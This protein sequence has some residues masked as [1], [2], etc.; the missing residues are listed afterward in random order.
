M[1]IT[2]WI[3]MA[4]AAVKGSVSIGSTSKLAVVD[5]LFD[6]AYDN[7]SK[8]EWIV[9]HMTKAYKSLVYIC[10]KLDYFRTFIPSVWL[11]YYDKV[12]N[13]LSTFRDMLEDGKIE[14]SEIERLIL[15]TRTAIET[16]RK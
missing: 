6:W 12:L 16:W 2:M 7:Y 14:R 1:K 9:T 15:C 5:Y 3:G 8:V 4:W 11:G 10:E 13:A